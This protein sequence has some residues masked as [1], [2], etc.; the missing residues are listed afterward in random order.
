MKLSLTSPCLA[1]GLLMGLGSAPE[2]VARHLLSESLARLQQQMSLFED[3]FWQD[4]DRV[5]AIPSDAERNKD[6]MVTIFDKEV[7]KLPEITIEK[8]EDSK[9]KANRELSLVIKD[10]D[11]AKDALKVELDE[12]EGYAQLVI[13]HENSQVTLKIYP[14]GYT[15]SAEK[16]ITQEKKDEKGTVLGS[17]SY[18]AYNSHSQSFPFTVNVRAIKPELSDKTLKLT[19]GKRDAKRAI[20]VE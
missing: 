16:K 19:F 6:G 18:T 17:S 15:V 3:M 20:P 4:F 12:D 14:N 9:N 7:V 13:P 11:V 5:L 10:L 2:L 8:Q 1:L